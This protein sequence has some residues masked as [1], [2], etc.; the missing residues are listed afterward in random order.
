MD[1]LK[2]TLV[3]KTQYQQNFYEFNN[4]STGC[5]TVRLVWPWMHRHVSWRLKLLHVFDHKK[6]YMLLTK[7]NK[8]KHQIFKNNKTAVRTTAPSFYIQSL[9]AGLLINCEHSKKA[10][11]PKPS[12]QRHLFVDSTTTTLTH[13]QLD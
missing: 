4:W 3:Q 10:V 8:K 6:Y 11:E 13:S 12:Q 2:S 7:T 5:L 9:N 1:V